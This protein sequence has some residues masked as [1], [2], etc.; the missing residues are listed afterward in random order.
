MSNHHNCRQKD[1][2]RAIKSRFYCPRWQWHLLSG[3][4]SAT[5]LRRDNH[6]NTMEAVSVCV[7]YRQRGRGRESETERAHRQLTFPI[8]LVDRGWPSG[9]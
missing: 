3:V 1:N 7:C 2:N 4:V 9:K 6:S 5:P 8:T